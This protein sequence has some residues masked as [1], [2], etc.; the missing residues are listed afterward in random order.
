MINKIQSIEAKDA[1]LTGARKTNED[2]H[3]CIFNLDGSNK[4]IAPINIF[5]VFD[6]HGGAFCS[7]FLSDHLPGIMLSNKMKY[8]LKKPLVRAVFDYIQNFL[9]EKYFENTT[10]TG[11][12]C[13]VACQFIQGD[14]IYLNLINIGDSKCIMCRDNLALPLT[15]EHRP[16]SFEE[17]ARILALGGQITQSPGDDP[18]VVGLSV[19]RSVGDLDAYPY[20]VPEPDLYKYKLTDDDKFIVLGCDG[21][22]DYCTPDD[23]VTFILKKCYDPTTQKRINVPDIAKLL[24]EYAIEKGSTDNVTVI[25]VFLR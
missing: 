14:N 15:K 10:E 3:V 6:G 22:Y 18:R 24:A 16:S 21:L 8:P 19:S 12:T 1:S 25:I 17:T 2:K 20:V 5:G 13:L 11:S 4:N 23:I 7:R 9:K